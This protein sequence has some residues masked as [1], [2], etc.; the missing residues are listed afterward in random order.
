MLTVLE[1]KRPLNDTHSNQSFIAKGTS[2][3]NKVLELFAF[4]VIFFLPFSKSLLE[5]SSSL[6]I[7]TWM[8]FK[9]RAA[10]SSVLVSRRVH[11]FSPFPFLALYLFFVACSVLT[12][13]YRWLSFYTFFSKTLEYALIFGIFFDLAWQS[14]DFVKKAIATFSV[15]SSLAVFN[16]F[17]QL[18]L[19]HDL[20]RN[21]AGVF[22]ISSSGFVRLTSSFSSPNGFSAYLELLAPLTVAV[23]FYLFSKKKIA[24]GAGC[25]FL[26]ISMIVCLAST[27]TRGFWVGLI[28]SLLILGMLHPKKSWLLAGLIVGAVILLLPRNE[29]IL[30][31]IKLHQILN[32]DRIHWI[33]EAS[34]IFSENPWLGTGLNTYARIAPQYKSFDTGG[35]YP[36]NSYFQL[37]AEIGFLGFSSFIL[38][39]GS[40]LLSIWKLIKKDPAKDS[41]EAA[42]LKGIMGGLMIFLIHAFLDNHF[43]ALQSAFTFWILLGVSRG[44]AE[45]IGY[46]G[47]EDISFKSVRVYSAKN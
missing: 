41:F 42:G 2:R 26:S 21:R 44:A 29:D 4:S 11:P 27:F 3:W 36:H 28:L 38:F 12:S 33:Q 31:A 1:M 7:V 32:S 14:R 6:L 46:P 35:V 22:E 23:T 19:G 30:S 15:S 8:V 40:C 9:L 25:A 17:W 18:A 47:E 20:I 13:N 10:Q 43:F 24:W 34:Q 37:L 45:R 5:L 16:G 39:I